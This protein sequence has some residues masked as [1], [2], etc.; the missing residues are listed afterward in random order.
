MVVPDDIA[1]SLGGLTDL[2]GR[3]LVDLDSY[4]DEWNGSFSF[5][6]VDPRHDAG[7]S[8]QS[9]GRT[10]EIG[11]LVGVRPGRAQVAVLISETMRLND[12]R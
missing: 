4:R 9:S 10:Q 11:A 1:R 6:F 7:R 3:P 2:D 12:D 5:T 8:R